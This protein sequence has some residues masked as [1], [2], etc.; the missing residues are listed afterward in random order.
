[1]AQL[2]ENEA[3]V[4]LIRSNITENLENKNGKYKTITRRGHNDQYTLSD[5]FG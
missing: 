3:S 2:Y 4:C 5:I 1:V